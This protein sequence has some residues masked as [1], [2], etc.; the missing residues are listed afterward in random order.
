MMDTMAKPANMEIHRVFELIEGLAHKARSK[1]P[2]QLI[3][4]NPLPNMP[5]T[6]SIGLRFS[7][8]RCSLS[9]N[10]PALKSRTASIRRL[11]VKDLPITGIEFHEM[12]FIHTPGAGRIEA[13]TYAPNN[14]NIN[15]RCSQRN[16]SKAPVIIV[17]R[18]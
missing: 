6:D 18:S 1:T 5:A 12:D 4:R 8:V 7:A 10:N 9:T 3:A 14:R 13:N 2:I 16:G 17:G 11:V 15:P